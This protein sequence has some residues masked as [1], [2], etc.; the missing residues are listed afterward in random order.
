MP[1]YCRVSRQGSPCSSP[2]IHRHLGDGWVRSGLRPCNCP[3]ELKVPAFLGSSL[4]SPHHSPGVGFRHFDGTWQ[5][6]KYRFSIQTLLD[7]V[8]MGLQFSE[9]CDVQLEKS[10]YFQKVFCL[11][12]LFLLSA[13]QGLSL[14]KLKSG[15]LT[16]ILFF[17][18][19]V[20]GWYAFSSIP[21][22]VVFFFFCLNNVYDIQG[23]NCS[24]QW[25]W[26]KIHLF[27]PLWQQR[28][29]QQYSWYVMGCPS[30]DIFKITSLPLAFD[31]LICCV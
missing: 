10:G 13:K 21:F 1:H 27:H 4:L 19:Q 14:A 24:S 22:G 31:C 29:L 23:F 25:E 2:A 8:A 11:T 28:I 12:R 3:V 7:G 20:T 15:D 5:E 16:T 30:F 6:W 17:E 26:D 18:S 9:H